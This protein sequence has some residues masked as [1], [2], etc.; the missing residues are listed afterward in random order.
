MW[1][2]FFSLRIWF[3][4]I[5]IS[6]CDLQVDRN[7]TNGVSNVD[8]NKVSANLIEPCSGLQNLYTDLIFQKAKV[9]LVTSYFR[10]DHSED[11]FLPCQIVQK[12]SLKFHS[13]DLRPVEII[14][15]VDSFEVKLLDRGEFFVL[16]NYITSIGIVK[17]GD[18][19]FIWL[20]GGGVISN[21]SEYYALLTLEGRLLYYS[22]STKHDHKSETSRTPNRSMGDFESIMRKCKLSELDINNPVCSVFVAIL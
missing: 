18:N 21:Q 15:D 19:H 12:Q 13:G 22:Y 5:G 6:S 11:N 16:E 20:T 4:L 2:D 8:Q 1:N 17:G 7:S 10:N 9:E 3:L 14:P